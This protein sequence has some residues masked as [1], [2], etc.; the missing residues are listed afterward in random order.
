MDLPEAGDFLLKVGSNDGFKCWFNGEEVGRFDGGRVYAPDQDVLEVHGRRGVNTVLLKISQMG[1]GWSFGARL[2][3][4]DGTPIDLRE[5][6][7]AVILPAPAFG[8]L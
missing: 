4:A 1:G 3:A 2:T 8:S 6:R 7:E 5:R